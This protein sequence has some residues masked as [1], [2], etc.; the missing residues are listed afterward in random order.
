MHGLLCHELLFHIYI[1]I[2]KCNLISLYITCIC[3]LGLAFMV[4]EGTTQAS[5]GGRQ[6]ITLS[7][8]DA[9]G[10]DQPSIS[11]SVDEI[12]RVVTLYYVAQVV[13]NLTVILLHQPPKCLDY[14][15]KLLCLASYF[16]LKCNLIPN[17][18]RNLISKKG[19]GVI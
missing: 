4:S 9:Y 6:L 7:N 13:L 2:P 17:K 8:H 15:H 11:N 19:S 14:R 10:P 16:Y 12:G 1:Y 18:G 5:K 3:V